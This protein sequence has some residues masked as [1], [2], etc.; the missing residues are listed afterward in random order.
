MGASKG[1]G[2]RFG[3]CTGGI[4]VILGH[5]RG[6]RGAYLAGGGAGEGQGGDAKFT[7]LEILF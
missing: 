2:G 5:F 3:A 6:A 7:Y 1:G 4:M